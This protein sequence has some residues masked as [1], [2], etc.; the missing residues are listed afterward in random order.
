MIK[1]N[2]GYA[3]RGN[4]KLETKY[5]D[6]NHLK[7]SI[8]NALE[9]HLEFACLGETY[10]LWLSKINKIGV[11]VEIWMDNTESSPSCQGIIHSDGEVEILSTHEQI[12]N[13]MIYVG[14]QFPAK[15]EYRKQIMDYSLKIG[16]LLSLKGCRE[17]YGVDFVAKTAGEDLIIYAV[18]INIR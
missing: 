10:D 4:S 12:L 16:H 11:I 1:Q 5:F 3:G 18:E 7:K 2:V 14:C 8:K 6:S 17:R 15:D 9:N 13:G